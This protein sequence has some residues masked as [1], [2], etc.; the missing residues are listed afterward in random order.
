MSSTELSKLFESIG[1]QGIVGV[2]L[3]LSLWVNYLLYKENKNLQNQ[4]VIDAQSSQKTLLGPLENVQQT[5]DLIVQL[6]RKP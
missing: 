3:V 1:S 5:M 2:I 6:L 4:R